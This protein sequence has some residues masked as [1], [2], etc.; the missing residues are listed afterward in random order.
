MIRILF[1]CKNNRSCSPMAAAYL[2]HRLEELGATDFEV[3]S[4]GF[5]AQRQETVCNGA[6]E[7]LEAL[8][9]EPLR[10]GTE[11]LQLFM[12][13]SASLILCMTSQQQEL[14]EKKYPSAVGKTRTLMSVIHSERDIFEPRS[15]DA[16][17]HG[18]CLTLMRAALDAL[19]ERLA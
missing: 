18:H 3:T 2:K 11:A 16:A 14:L 9:L 17:N 8:G 13:K 15:T 12:I 5:S 10:I 19:A 1:V 7:A 6:R 4:A